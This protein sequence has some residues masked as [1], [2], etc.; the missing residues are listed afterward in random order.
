MTVRDVTPALGSLADSSALRPYLYSLAISS[1][2]K[3][4]C[5][6]MSSPSSLLSMK[7][8]ER[9]AFLCCSMLAGSS[10]VFLKAST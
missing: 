8:M 9:P 3:T 4:S 6:L 7:L 5:F 2:Q 1:R 10:I